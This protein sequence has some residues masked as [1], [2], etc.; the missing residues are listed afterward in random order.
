MNKVVMPDP[1][2]APIGR[3]ERVW[4]PWGITENARVVDMPDFGG[5]V[6][7]AMVWNPEH[8]PGVKFSVFRVR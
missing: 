4:A 3:P 1:A 6:R 2:D 7:Y 8:N 5:K